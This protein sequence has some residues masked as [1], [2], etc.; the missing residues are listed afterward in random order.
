MGV[1]HAAHGGTGHAVHGE[2]VGGVG[3]PVRNWT[4]TTPNDLHVVGECGR[5]SQTAVPNLL[6]LRLRQGIKFATQTPR[7]VGFTRAGHNYIL[8]QG[9]PVH[10][11]GLNAARHDNLASQDGRAGLS[12]HKVGAAKVVQTTLI[13]GLSTS[14]EPHKLTRVLGRQ[15]KGKAAQNTQ[16]RAMSVGDLNLAL[17][18]ERQGISGQTGSVPIVVTRALTSEVASDRTIGV[19]VEPPRTVR[20]RS[21]GSLW[22]LK[23]PQRTERAESRGC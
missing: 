16:H 6:R 11:V 10:T 5:H 7:V 22:R 2:W 23:L 18:L 17:L 4:L 20:G 19:V 9:T 3:G 14:L 1:G 12:V 13:E 15:L 21:T 8:T